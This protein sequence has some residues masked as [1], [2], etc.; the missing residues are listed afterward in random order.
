MKRKGPYRAAICGFSILMLSLC[1]TRARAETWPTRPVHMIVGGA[2]GSAPDIIARIIGEKLSAAWGQQTVIDDKPGAAG[3]LGTEAAAHA[4]PDGYT[5]LFGQAAP[6]SMNR[7]VFKSLPFDVDRDLVPVINI[8]LSPMII[9]ANPK[10]AAKT[11]GELIALCKAQPGKLTFGTSSSRNIPHLTGE[12]LK[13][14]SGCD[15]THVPYAANTQAIQD[16][17]RGDTQLMIDGIPVLLGQVKAARLNAL[18]VSS[19]K[20]LPGLEAIPTVA[21][22]LPGFVSNGWFAILAPT[23]TPADV[24]SRVNRDVNTALQDHE[25]ADRMRDLG[26]YAEGGSPED[27]AR[28]M[29][30][31]TAQWQRIVRDAEIQPE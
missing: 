5:L 19:S 1:A 7:W 3:N 2:A 23:G 20:R 9:V 16:V 14:A 28:F 22:T 29:K 8:G 11:I 18:A 27:L 26:V 21:E 10:L 6:L 30:L 31:D 25:V 12:L 24:V 17:V 15:M 13:H 4:T